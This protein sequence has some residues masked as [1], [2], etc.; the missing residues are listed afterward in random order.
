MRI[1]VN[2]ESVNYVVV[3]ISLSGNKS[4]FFDCSLKLFSLRYAN[5][6]FCGTYNV[7]LYHD[8]AHIVGAVVKTNNSY[9][10][11]LRHMRSLDVFEIVEEY[12]RK[13]QNL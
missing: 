1:F 4:G 13:C 11:G 7:L 12:P 5:L 10:Y 6:K 2:F 8:T 9:F 3:G